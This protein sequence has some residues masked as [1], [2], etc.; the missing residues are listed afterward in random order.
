MSQGDGSGNVDRSWLRLE[1]EPG[2]MQNLRCRKCRW[3]VLPAWMILESS[4][5]EFIAYLPSLLCTESDNVDCG[6]CSSRLGRWHAHTFPDANDDALPSLQALV[7]S[8]KK[9]E[10]WPTR[11]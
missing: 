7:F 6:K 9:V 1:T 4:Q 2:A 5:I 11:P 3:T 10:L 8:A